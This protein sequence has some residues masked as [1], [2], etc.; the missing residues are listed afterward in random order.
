MISIKVD[1]WRNKV[2]INNPQKQVKV[3]MTQ[4]RALKDTGLISLSGTR[5]N[6]LMEITPLGRALLN[7]EM[8]NVYSKAMI[9]LHAKNPMRDAIYN[10]SRPFLNLLLQ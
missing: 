4:I 8:E 9:G 6:K 10:Q 3:V 1:W 7:N 5:N 2:I